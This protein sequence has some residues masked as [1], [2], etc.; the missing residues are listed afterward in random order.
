MLGDRR[1]RRNPDQRGRANRSA[2]RRPV[3]GE[4]TE[5]VQHARHG[6][7]HRQGTMR[8]PAPRQIVGAA[9]GGQR[10]GHGVV[11]RMHIEQCRR[12]HGRQKQHALL[13]REHPQA[14][15]GDLDRGVA[16]GQALD[17]TPGGRLVD[18]VLVVVHREADVGH[19]LAAGAEAARPDRLERPPQGAHPL[20]QILI[21]PQFHRVCHDPRSRPGRI[22]ARG[23][24]PGCRGNGETPAQYSSGAGGRLAAGPGVDARRRSWDMLRSH[25]ARSRASRRGA[26]MTKPEVL[27]LLDVHP[28][29]TARLDETYALHRLWEA[30]DRDRLVAEVAPRVRGAVTNGIVGMKGELI[31]A[32]PALEIIGVLGVGV[33]AV[34]LATAKARGVRVTNTPD[35]LTEGVAELAIALLLAVARR[36]PFNDRF[37][38]AGRWPR[39]GDPAL[40]S[41]LAGRRLGIVG[42]GRIGRR[43][44]QLAE[45]FGMEIR[46]GGAHR[47]ADVTWPYYNDLV[48]LARDVDCLMLTCKG[49][50][51]TP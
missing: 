4:V 49:G 40:A 22:L 21:E 41:S 42:L 33:D 6:S 30:G 5:A 17:Q 20:R 16:R 36:I 19:G 24:M 26:V 44:A 50:G 13:G 32:L 48:A 18:L 51:E 28:G 2:K 27:A 35:V 14:C 23:F 45:G 25:L 10:G 47:K 37:V 9:G 8:H 38:R 43:V 31:D 12:D 46:Y 7:E 1:E 11:G 39:E 29:T 34:D 15:E 3:G